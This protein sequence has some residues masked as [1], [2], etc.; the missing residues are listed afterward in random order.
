M[1]YSTRMSHTAHATLRLGA[2]AL[3]ALVSLVTACAAPDPTRVRREVDVRSLPPTTIEDQAAEAARRSQPRPEHRALAP[4]AGEWAVTV[5]D[6][7]EH[8]GE[9]GPHTGSARI[10]WVLGGRF[11][12]WN[13]FLGIGGHDYATTGYLGFDVNSAEY[14]LLMISDLATGM[15][16]ARGR[17]DVSQRG[18]RLTLEVADPS[19]GA[20][21]RAQSV[22][23]VVDSDHFVLEQIGLDA[24]GVER[25][26]RRT[27]YRRVGHAPGG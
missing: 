5:V 24:A 26:V 19:N 15:G 1:T 7:D 20:I 6:V 23:R 4:L 14:Q 16:V 22:L 25:V 13:A 11:L 21:R 27:H 2:G 9:S 12:S 3:V 8:G 17:G 18:I 10:E